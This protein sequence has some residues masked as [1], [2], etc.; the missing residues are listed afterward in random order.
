MSD[1]L[2]SWYEFAQ[3]KAMAPTRSEP[4]AI[5]CPCCGRALYKDTT[6]ILTSLPPKYR[7]FCVAC[8]WS[9]YA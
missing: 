6:V 7:Y 1:K 2:E 4:T 3:E 8:K 5:A 9:D